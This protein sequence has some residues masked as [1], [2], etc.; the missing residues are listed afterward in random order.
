[1]SR[2]AAWAAALALAAALLGG[3]AAERPKPTPLE[4]YAPKASAHL[5]WSQRLGKLDFPLEPA[6]GVG[7]VIVADSAGTVIALA[8][9]NG[10][11]LWRASAGAALSAGVGSDGRFASVVTR[12]NEVVTFEQ[13][14][15]V[16]RKRVPSSVVTPPFVAGE[17][18][19][20]MG[21]DRVVHAFDALDGRRL[22][23]LQRAG[24]ALT[25]ALPGVLA[26]YHDTL[27]VGQGPQLVGVDP[28]R[29]SVRWSV[30][31]ASPR[32]TNEVE[33]LADLVGPPARHGER[34]C[35]RAFQSAVGCAD[36]AR[37]SVLWTRNTGGVQPVAV[38]AERVYG[39]DA[40]DRITAWRAD[41]GDVAWSSERMLN[42]GL[43]GPL[44]VGAFVV[45]GDSEGYLHFLAAASGEPQLRLATDG[46]PVLGAPQ[47][48]GRTMLVVTR[49]G[50]VF[51][52]RQN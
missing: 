18:V 37:A 51:A 26:A 22:W 20:V 23:T 40:V 15:E 13:G 21:V 35:A 49:A 28:L 41:N 31:L 11:E 10:A 29:G 3:C 2:R 32:G 50:G 8:L 52:L 12:R 46:S 30:P 43:S 42:R 45:F 44:A 16:W 14:R 38:D 19:F 7:Q 36:A 25:L 33:R 5:A 6:A 24:D 39:A 34:I 4:T 27:L 9:D 47:L 1:M 48:A 17:R